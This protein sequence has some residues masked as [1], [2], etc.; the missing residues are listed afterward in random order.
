[1]ATTTYS[2]TT[3]SLAA[4]GNRTDAAGVAVTDYTAE[5][6]RFA[7]QILTPGYLKP[8]TAFQVAA[9]D[10]P[11]MSIKVGSGTAKA[12]YYVVEGQTGG[13]GNYV[14][15]LDVTSLTVA[16]PAADASQARTDEIYLVVRDNAY[17]AS[18]RGLP[19]IGYRKGDLG[20]AA[21]GPDAAWGASALLATVSVP[22]LETAI[23]TANIT[24]GRQAAALLDGLVDTAALIPKSLVDAKGDL[25]VASAADTVARVSVGTNGR[26]LMAD[27]A[28][29]AGVQW[30]DRSPVTDSDGSELTIGVSGY[31]PGSTVVGVSF[32]APPSGLVFVTSSGRLDSNAESEAEAF[33]TWE[34]RVGPTVGSGTVVVAADDSFA[35]SVRGFADTSVGTERRAVVSGSRREVVP[36][37]LTPGSDYNVRLMHRSTFAGSKVRYRALVVEFV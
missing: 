15:R 12:D 28:Q 2:D 21:P 16:V 1:M 20:G 14:V 23:E 25:L 5:E 18:A 7:A 33:L 36:F 4:I 9:Q 26:V 8:T 19:Q 37:T 17:D 29:S 3:F 13:Q 27:S 34:M 31:E 11:N 35:L 30:F 22:A 10:T 6:A 32:T 24:D